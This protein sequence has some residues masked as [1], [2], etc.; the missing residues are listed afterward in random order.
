MR[1]LVTALFVGLALVVA[2]L[3]GTQ[4]SEGC[5]SVW[6]AVVGS[7]GTL[8]IAGYVVY[9]TLHDAGC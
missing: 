2:Y 8:L 6:T 4:A 5:I 9:H 1:N 3:L 7:G